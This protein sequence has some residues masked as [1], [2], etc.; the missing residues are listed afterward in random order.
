MMSTKST[1]ELLGYA[2]GIITLACGFL[3][4]Q[5]WLLTVILGWFGVTAIGF[6]KAVVIVI[7]IDL[8]TSSLKPRK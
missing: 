2:A 3:A 4:F 8:I 6:W 1:S 7:F 5:A